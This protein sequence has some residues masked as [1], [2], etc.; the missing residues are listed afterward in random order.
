MIKFLYYS[1]LALCIFCCKPIR[2][3]EGLPIPSHLNEILIPFGDENCESKVHG[4]IKCSCGSEK[5]ALKYYGDKSEY[6]KDRVIKVKEFYEGFLIRV[7]AECID[8]S[9]EHL[10]CDSDNH[11]WNGW[12]VESPTVNQLRP[13]LEVWH[14]NVCGISNHLLDIEIQSEGRADYKSETGDPNDSDDWKEAFSWITIGI[15]CNSCNEINNE[16]ISYETM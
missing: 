6:K 4:K 9:R 13:Q 11:G 15:R 14:C 5:F 1:L 8:C 2:T 3:N 7:V 16:W 12:V 10:I